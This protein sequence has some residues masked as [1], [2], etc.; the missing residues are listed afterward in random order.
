MSDPDPSLG[1]SIGP[2]IPDPPDAGAATERA[3]QKRR[4]IAHL[5]AVAFLVGLIAVLAYEGIQTVRDDRSQPTAAQVALNL[6]QD[7][8][9][10]DFSAAWRLTAGDGHVGQTQSQW[11]AAMET[12][13]DAP[14]SRGASYRI[15]AA[16]LEGPYVRVLLFAGSARQPS[17]AVDLEYGQG[18]WAVRDLVAPTTPPP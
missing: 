17:V 15:D 7:L 4:R 1:T 5:I 13:G 9:R 12:G 14:L 8:S 18:G 16:S 3:L 6:A 2:V 11:I 10:G